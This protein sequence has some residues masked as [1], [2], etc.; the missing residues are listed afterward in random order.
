ML[1]SHILAK[2]QQAVFTNHYSNNIGDILAVLTIGYV[3]EDFEEFWGISSNALIA[4]CLS[5][6]PQS[7]TMAMTNGQSRQSV[8]LVQVLYLL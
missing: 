1:Y 4:L 7:S 3:C 5:P 6:L 8:L 2:L